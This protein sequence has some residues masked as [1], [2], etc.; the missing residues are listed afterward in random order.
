MRRALGL[1]G[2]LW[3]AGCSMATPLPEAA[4]PEAAPPE[5][6]PAPSG[7][8]AFATRVERDREALPGAL[9]ADPLGAAAVVACYRELGSPLWRL[10]AA[11]IAPRLIGPLADPAPSVRRAAAEALAGLG[12]AATSALPALRANLADPDPGVR[13]ATA[14]CLGAIGP[15]ASSAVA[16]LSALLR[17]T[18]EAETSAAHALGR[19]GGRDAAL[20]LVRRVEQGS[21]SAQDGREAAVSALGWAGLPADLAVPCLLRALTKESLAL[22]SVVAL[23]HRRARGSE[24]VA[25]LTEALARAGTATAPGWRARPLRLQLLLALGEQGGAAGS[26]GPARDARRRDA[27]LAATREL[28]RQLAALDEELQCAAASALVRLLPVSERGAPLALLLG[29]L[30]HGQEPGVRAA[31]VLAA[32]EACGELARAAAPA[33]RRLLEEEP[34]Y[35]LARTLLAVSPADGERAVPA[36]VRELQ[37]PD[38]VFVSIAAALPGDRQAEAAR[39]LGELG[40]RA[41]AALPALRAMWNDDRIDVRRAV[42]AAVARIAAPLW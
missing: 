21:A 5:A 12:N 17:R 32:L 27:E 2:A 18:D 15:E 9:P 4:P 33:L 28:R 26:R 7:P 36:F 10:L 23:R 42:R 35:A 16:E 39:R 25:A 41:L 31:G 6:A 14:S 30:D 38:P 1:L 20:A 19:I 13:R 29:R 24:V 37:R 40:R 8:G 22:E 11:D 3:L 34:D